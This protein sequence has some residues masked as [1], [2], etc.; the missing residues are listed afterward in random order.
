[1][2]LIWNGQLEVRRVWGGSGPPTP[3]EVLLRTVDVRDIGDPEAFLASLP[4]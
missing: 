4:I 2:R 1:M 3:S